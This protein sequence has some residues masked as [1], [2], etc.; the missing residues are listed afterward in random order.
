MILE[1]ELELHHPGEFFCPGAINVE[2]G[3]IRCIELSVHGIATV[4]EVIKGEEK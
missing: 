2:D 3:R 4:Q 1:F